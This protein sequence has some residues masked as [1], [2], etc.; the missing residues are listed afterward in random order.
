MKTLLRS[1]ALEIP[2]FDEPDS[3]QVREFLK[4]IGVSELSLRELLVTYV[5]PSAENTN[6]PRLCAIMR[7]IIMGGLLPP[8]DLEKIK[9]VPVS[10]STN[11]LVVSAHAVHL[12]IEEFIPLQICIPGA[13]L[14]LDWAAEKTLLAQLRSYGLRGDLSKQELLTVARYV[15]EHE[16]CDLAFL[17]SKYLS[18]KLADFGHGFFQEFNEIAWLPAQ[19]KP[20]GWVFPWKKEDEC[21]PLL[22]ASDSAV[23]LFVNHK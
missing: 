21:L 14:H 16:D 17:L 1:S 7:E 19:G 2:V 18:S 9:C 12:N 23:G 10:D 20:N 8:L 3:A 22:R 13:S 5:L 15:Q 6:D 11:S 4:K